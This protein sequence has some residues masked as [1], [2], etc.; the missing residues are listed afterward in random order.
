MPGGALSCGVGRGEKF[1]LTRPGGPRRR[2][3]T[4]CRLRRILQP[5]VDANAVAE[6]RNK[7]HAGQQGTT[8][9]MSG[10]RPNRSAI[11]R[12]N[13][14]GYV[15]E[16]AEEAAQRHAALPIWPA[17]PGPGF[18]GPRRMVLPALKSCK[19]VRTIACTKPVRQTSMNPTLVVISRN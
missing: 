6:K 8:A 13:S 3:F 10:L 15:A 19:P 16:Q 14:E 5:T 18:C 7:R 9:T 17:L 2:R 11:M 4:R 12:T 1:G